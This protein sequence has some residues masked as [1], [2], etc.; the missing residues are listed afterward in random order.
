MIKKKLLFT[1]VVLSF[2]YACNDHTKERELMQR[3]ADLNRREQMFQAKEAE[4]LSLLKM[5]DSLQYQDS[6]VNIIA[7]PEEIS[8]QWNSKIVCVETS[9]SDYVIGDTRN[10]LWEFSQDSIQLLV[11]VY[12]KKDLIRVYASEYSN[13][14]ISLHYATDTTAQKFVDMKVYLS[15]IT[16]NKI[17]GYR[18]VSVNGLCSAKFTVEL[19]KITK[20]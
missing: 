1:A 12:N 16:P 5:R 9:C 6:I 8:G 15:E 3:E 19:N 18:T 17:S 14:Q 7:W 11:N 20:Q 2:L 10:D 13:N 4:Y